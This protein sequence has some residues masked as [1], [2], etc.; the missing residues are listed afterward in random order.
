MDDLFVQEKYRKNGIGKRLLDSIIEIGKKE[1]CE[2][3]RWQVSNWN[4]NAQEFYKSLGV[5]IDNREYNC[6]LYL[7]N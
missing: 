7:K 3:L 5:H 6:D 1:K 4:K 2:K